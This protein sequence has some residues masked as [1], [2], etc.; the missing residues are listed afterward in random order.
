MK[1]RLFFGHN[2][3]VTQFEHVEDAACG[4]FCLA[5]LSINTV[6]DVIVL[7][8]VDTEYMRDP[9]VCFQAM[10]SNERRQ[11]IQQSFDVP[12]VRFQQCMQ[13]TIVL[14]RPCVGLLLC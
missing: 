6:N 10:E 13:S 5:F 9:W 12:A 7:S 2:Q 11:S 8:F 3:S 4:L 1:P 14:C